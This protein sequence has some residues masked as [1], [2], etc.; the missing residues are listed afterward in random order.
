MADHFTA[1]GMTTQRMSSFES[2][3]L[4]KSL[5]TSY[6]GVLVAWAQ[7]MDRF[8]ASVDADYWETP[9]FFE[10]IGFFPPVSFEP[11]YIG[12]H[13]V[14]P[15]LDLLEQVRRSP[16]IDAIRQ[17]ER[18]A[19]TWNGRPQGVLR[20]TTQP[21]DHRE[22][23]VKTTVPRLDID[24]AVIG[25]GPYGLSAAAHL[26][27]AGVELRV[28]GQ[29]MS[30]WQG[31]PTGL[32]LRSNWTAT[33][34]AEY[35]GELSLARSAPR[36]TPNRPTGTAGSLHRL[37]PVG[38]AA[39]RAGRG[40]PPGPGPG[41]KPGGFRLTLDDG[42]AVSARRVVVAAGI[43]PFANRPEVA[44]GLPPELASHTGDHRDF[45]RFRG[46]RVLVV[47]GGQSALEYAA[48]LRRKRRP[49]RGGRPGRPN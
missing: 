34:I 30:F 41:A 49:S 26:R 42:T 18:A 37:R 4:A 5:E 21:T 3:E 25:A 48:M 10:E 24:V 15:N 16:V 23:D 39:G 47:G 45:G 27:R 40:P 33:C 19:R 7:E 8:A 36:P 14:M 32:L 28:F 31:M 29:P 35:R 1:A 13:C 44:A 38:P 20:R 9:G 12:G 43:E 17:F 11:G 22:R 46:A 6:F 2:L